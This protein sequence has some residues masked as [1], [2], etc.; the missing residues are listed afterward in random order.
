MESFIAK[1]PIEL[2][3]I[4]FSY[5]NSSSL[6]SLIKNND[7]KRV[8]DENHIEL[9]SSFNNIT[10]EEMIVWNLLSIIKQTDNYMDL[11]KILY[12]ADIKNNYYKKLYNSFNIQSSSMFTS[13]TDS[14]YTIKLKMGLFFTNMINNNDNLIKIKNYS[15]LTFDEIEFIFTTM[16][17]YSDEFNMELLYI[18]C[19]AKNKDRYKLN[20]DRMT[21]V[22]KLKFISNY[23]NSNDLNYYNSFICTWPEINFNYYIIL[24]MQNVKYHIAHKLTNPENKNIEKNVENF[25]TFRKEFNIDDYTLYKCFRSKKDMNNIKYFQTNGI[26][27]DIDTLCMIYKYP[28]NKEIIDSI[29]AKNKL[30]NL[31]I[32]LWNNTSRTLSLVFNVVAQNIL[33]V[34]EIFNKFTIYQIK[35]IRIKEFM[36]D[37]DLNSTLNN[38]RQFNIKS[39]A[40]F[41]K[42]SPIINNN[43][44]TVR[45]KIKYIKRAY[46]DLTEEKYNLYLKYIKELDIK[47]AYQEITDEQ[48]EAFYH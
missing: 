20:Y 48:N 6:L 39:I 1:L 41:H 15:K 23:N 28:K 29:L 47:N 19:V 46:Y 37:G 31:P 36:E 21:L 13:K 38:F 7:M 9:L 40:S 14:K 25:M 2:I 16:K 22:K 42:V 11:C 32:K 34:D 27:Y 26:T 24:I 10:N 35:Q 43:N 18:T 5:T 3:S 33:T 44:F 8:I 4:I 12:Y 45:I 17:N 30:Y